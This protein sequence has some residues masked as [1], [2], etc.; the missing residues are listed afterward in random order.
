[1]KWRFE[2]ADFSSHIAIWDGTDK[3]ILVPFKFPERVSLNS[4]ADIISNPMS[5][6][7]EV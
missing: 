2:S 3:Q 1:M 4:V 7:W 5:I 6:V